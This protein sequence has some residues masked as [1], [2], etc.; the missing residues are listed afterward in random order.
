MFDPRTLGELLIQLI[1]DGNV[2]Y[3]VNDDGHLVMVIRD[4]ILAADMLKN[5][6]FMRVMLD[7]E[8]E[9]E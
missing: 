6:N 3:W 2:G 5:I 4:R 1:P 8:G 7:E 9:S